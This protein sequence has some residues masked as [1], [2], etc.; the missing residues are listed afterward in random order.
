[1]HSVSA[2][3]IILTFSSL[4]IDQSAYYVVTQIDGCLSD[5]GF[6]GAPGFDDQHPSFDCHD[7]HP[8]VDCSCVDMDGWC[9]NYYMTHN[10]EDCS[11]IVDKRQLPYALSDSATFLW[12]LLLAV[13]GNSL[14]MCR[15]RGC[16]CC[17]SSSST[18]GAVPGVLPVQTQAQVVMP[19]AEARGFD[20]DDSEEQ[21][22]TDDPEVGPAG[23]ESSAENYP[24]QM[25]DTAVSGVRHY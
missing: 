10:Y 3:S 16:C 14:L 12:F 25:M 20:D 24:L 23:H 11:P 6:F 19:N 15:Y 5:S 18:T 1:M 13:V 8:S 9:N 7:R 22:G 4:I 2:L 21:K 17:N